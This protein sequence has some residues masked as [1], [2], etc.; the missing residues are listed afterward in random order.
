MVVHHRLGEGGYGR[1]TCGFGLTCRRL[2]IVEMP[3]ERSR[4]R[5]MGTPRSG[6]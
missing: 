5:N 2:E 1:R 4:R 3:V 6:G